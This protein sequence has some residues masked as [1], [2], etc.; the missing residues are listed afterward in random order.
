MEPKREPKSIKGGQ[1]EPKGRQRSPKGRQKGMQNGMPKKVADM[2]MESL[3]RASGSNG[4][5]ARTAP[6]GAM[7]VASLKTS[8]WPGMPTG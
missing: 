4:I 1:R 8:Q 6:T 5:S 2:A 7:R 3:E